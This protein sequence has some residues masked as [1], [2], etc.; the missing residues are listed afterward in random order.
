[1]PYR[2]KPSRVGAAPGLA[3]K[4]EILATEQTSGVEALSAIA[5][6]GCESSHL[7]RLHS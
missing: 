4:P 7:A 6:G 3:A 5:H 1:M 2:A